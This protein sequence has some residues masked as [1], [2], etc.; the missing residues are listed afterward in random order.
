M[1]VPAWA[2][3]PPKPRLVGKHVGK[4]GTVSAWF[5][6]RPGNPVPLSLAD[7][8]L[9]RVRVEAPVR[10]EV[11]VLDKP[12]ST[13]QWSLEARQ[14]ARKGAG[15]WEQEY[16]LGP[17]QPGEY[18]VE[19]PPL[20]YRS[21]GGE[22]QTVS[23]K[24][25]PVRVTATIKKAEPAS[26][27]D[28]TPIEEVPAGEP[29]RGWLLWAGLA[30]G[31]VL[32]GVTALVV[33]RRRV[34]KPP[35]LPPHEWALRELDRL[36]ASRPTSVEQVAAYHT[37]LSVVLRH[38]LERRFQIPAER[39]TSAEFMAAVHTSSELSA[40]Q[41]AAL[42]ELLCQCDL[43]KFARVWPSAEECQALVTR[44]R[45]FVEESAPKPTEPPA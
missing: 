22:W 15:V 23:W 21:D 34:P 30:L 28:I 1:C 36:A 12:K 14:P 35:A 20:R 37:A 43:A 26:A 32:L 42:G 16:L 9:V 11:E 10:L 44:A 4:P 6:A 39:Q 18:A 13:P 3:P 7:D 8:T 19:L 25:I 29:A 40:E 24:P 41:E 27:R 17:L 5:V 33:Q 31:V 38:Y 45:A 2:T